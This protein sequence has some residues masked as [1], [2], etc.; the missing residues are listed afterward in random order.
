MYIYIT[1]SFNDHILGNRLRSTAPISFGPKKMVQPHISS[2]ELGD[3]TPINGKPMV[4]QLWPFTN[5][6]WF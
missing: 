4:L 6:K 1:V 2:P 5:Y 3:P